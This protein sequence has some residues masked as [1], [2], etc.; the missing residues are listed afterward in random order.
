MDGHSVTSVQVAADPPLCETSYGTYPTLMQYET[1]P[2]NFCS[3]ETDHILIQ[4]G[5]H[6]TI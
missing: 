3:T 1:F 6:Y 4:C 5:R 2:I